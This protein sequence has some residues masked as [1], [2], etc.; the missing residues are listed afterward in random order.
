MAKP[1][2]MT[3]PAL[4]A[5][6]KA[7]GTALLPDPALLHHLQHPTARSQNWENLIPMGGTGGVSAEWEQGRC[8]C[9]MG[10]DLASGRSAQCHRGNV[11]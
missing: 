7:V 1:K 4:Q 6:T 5:H 2:P 9:A 8:P 10:R 11:I 3:V